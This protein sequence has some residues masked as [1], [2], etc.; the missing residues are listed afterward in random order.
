MLITVFANVSFGGAYATSIIITQ[1]L[2]RFYNQAWAADWGYMIL[3]TMSTQ[4]IGYGLAGLARASLVWSTQAIWPG[5]LAVIALNRSFHS[6][7]NDTVND[8]RITRLRFFGYVCLASGLYYIIPNYIF[9]ALS[10]FS[11]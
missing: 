11:W 5:S 10:Q 4:I 8:W 2:E 1:R 6:S 3:L 7:E 9:G